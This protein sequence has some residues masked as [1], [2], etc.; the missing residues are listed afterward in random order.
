VQ[1][2]VHNR[3]VGII[4]RSGEGAPNPA[5]KNGKA[6]G[7]D[8]RNNRDKE[9]LILFEPITAPVALRTLRANADGELWVVINDADA[10]RWDN[11][12]I[13]FLKIVVF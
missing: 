8:Y 13:F 7:Y 5:D 11:A 1:G 4:Q 3:V 2:V 12:G 6:P 9:R 10:Y